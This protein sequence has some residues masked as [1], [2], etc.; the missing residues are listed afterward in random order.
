MTFSF[1][2]YPERKRLWE[3]ALSTPFQFEEGLT[4]R[5]AKNYQFSGGG[6]Y[7]IISEGVIE[8]LD[9]E[10]ETITFELLE[11]AMI[12]EFKKT[13]RKYE[14]CTDEMVPQNPTKRYGIGYEN[15]KNF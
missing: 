4:D 3:N 11:Q 13:G 5:L 15:R 8:A 10:S 1:P 12:D 6:I 2:E 7:N 9:K 14:V